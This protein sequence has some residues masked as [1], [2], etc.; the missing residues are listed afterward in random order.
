MASEPNVPR[1]F[2]GGPWHE[3]EVEIPADRHVYRVPVVGGGEV[4][5]QRR[6]MAHRPTRTIRSFMVPDNWSSKEAEH[7]LREYLLRR[8]IAENPD[9]TL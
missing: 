3:R 1:L 2:L 8:W 5:Y 4:A 6:R 7:E 9:V